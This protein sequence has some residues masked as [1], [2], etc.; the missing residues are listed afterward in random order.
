MNR[1]KS[2]EIQLNFTY[3]FTFTLP[4]LLQS[5]WLFFDYF[6]VFIFFQHWL[7]LFNWLVIWLIWPNRR[8][9]KTETAQKKTKKKE[10]KLEICTVTLTSLSL[11]VMIRICCSWA[12]SRCWAYDRNR[13]RGIGFQPI[14]LSIQTKM[15]SMKNGSIIF[16]GM[17]NSFTIDAGKSIREGWKISIK[18]N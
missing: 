5:H 14:V 11:A 17:G 9:N 1:Y 10:P 4:N 3:A 13:K 12:S 8:H 18:L 16:F 7:V 6:S 2:I 15:V